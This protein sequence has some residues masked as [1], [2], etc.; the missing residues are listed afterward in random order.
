M[1]MYVCVILRTEITPEEC[2]TLMGSN[3]LNKNIHVH[4]HL[5]TQLTFILHSVH[6]AK[7]DNIQWLNF[8]THIVTIT[9]HGVMLTNL[10]CNT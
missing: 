1:Y 7:C 8:M 3:L 5:S 9:Q 2:K 6:V 10:R 4:L